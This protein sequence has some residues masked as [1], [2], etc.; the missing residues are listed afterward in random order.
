MI[1][2]GQRRCQIKAIFFSSYD[3]LAARRDG[4]APHESKI[5]AK[6]LRALKRDGWIQARQ[7]GSHVILK[8]PEKDGRIV[9]P[10]QTGMI[11]KPKTLESILERAGLTIDQLREL[12]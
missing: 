7:S 5:A 4:R 8:H 10:N 9:V 11:L 3:I 2:L 6:L 12:L 1:A